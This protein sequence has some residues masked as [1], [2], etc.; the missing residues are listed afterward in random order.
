MNFI[1]FGCNVGDT[2]FVTSVETRKIYEF[3]INCLKLFENNYTAHGYIR[4]LYRKFGEI[5]TEFSLKNLNK[6]VIFTDK[7]KAEEW[8]N[9]IKRSQGCKEES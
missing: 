8:L 3:R 1:D 6:R 7:R 2:L 5:P 9:I 4:K